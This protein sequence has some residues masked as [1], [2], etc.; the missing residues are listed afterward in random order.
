M[1]RLPARG[2][3]VA[4]FW[5]S[6]PGGR[7][8]P[9]VHRRC[10]GDHSCASRG[11][12]GARWIV[13]VTSRGGAGWAGCA[14]SAGLCGGTGPTG[15]LSVLSSP[16]DSAC[17]LCLRDASSSSVVLGGAWG[18]D[19]GGPPASEVHHG[20]PL[21]R[22]LRRLGLGPESH[23]GRHGGCSSQQAPR[24]GFCAR[25]HVFLFLA[26]AM[27]EGVSPK[28]KRRAQRKGGKTGSKFSKEYQTLAGNVHTAAKEMMGSKGTVIYVGKKR[29]RT[30]AEVVEYLTK[31]SASTA[32]KAGNHG[33]REPKKKGPAPR[34]LEQEFVG[35]YEWVV[36]QVEGA[37]KDSFLTV[38]RLKEK[39]Y[40]D[41]GIQVS[42][43]VLRFTL[44]RLGFKYCK[45]VGK[46]TSRRHEERVQRRLF[47][48]LKWVVLVSEK[49][50][51]GK[52]RWIPPVAF[53]DET[54]M[55]SAKFREHS[56]CAPV[57][58][59]AKRVDR[60]YDHN[61]E[62]DG[63][64]VNCIGCIFS[65]IDQPKSAGG[66][67]ECL[68]TWKSTWVGKNHRFS[69]KYVDAEAIEKFYRECVW[70]YVGEGGFVVLDNASTH[71][72]YTEEMK[73]MDEN[74]LETFIEEKLSEAPLG[75]YR[76]GYV[77]KEFEKLE[78]TAPKMRT[79]IKRHH[80][81]DTKLNEEAKRF[82]ITLR[83]LPQYYPECNAIERFWALLKRYYYDS[84]R[85]LPHKT[86]LAQAIEKIPKNYIQDCMQASLVWMHRKYE[87]MSKL[88][89]FGGKATEVEDDELVEEMAAGSDSDS[90]ASGASDDFVY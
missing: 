37:K 52:Y 54:F 80:L 74:D 18:S 50:P 46:W 30:T 26:P 41:K 43:K 4:M 20:L 60:T 89:K 5:V 36:E 88:T 64:R 35:F 68:Q 32:R 40:E 73:L 3:A 38:G 45:R 23:G 47:E 15:F 7:Q 57:K 31:V 29:L 21:C 39:L 87:K 70:E 71:K 61:S 22:W 51:D 56:I 17:A 77:T 19:R 84:P 49:C 14:L 1:G 10:V 76:A 67:M 11:P 6:T 44:K 62:G 86:R 13:T 63:T 42:R 16:S 65:H 85:S 78:K 72:Q 24:G 90:D 53:Q 59:G 9:A 75:S 79:F 58:K 34:D 66:G 81:M 2:Q 12:A 82:E 69:G 8:A 25:V 83:Y 27:K 33:P 48:F 28:K 55:Y